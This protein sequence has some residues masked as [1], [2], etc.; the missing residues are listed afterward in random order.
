MSAVTWRVGGAIHHVM[1]TDADTRLLS[2]RQV[3]GAHELH[4]LPGVLANLLDPV[5]PIILHS[6]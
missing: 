1:P 5:G 6:T 2:R 3:S 4:A